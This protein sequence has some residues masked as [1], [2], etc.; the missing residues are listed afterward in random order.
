MGLATEPAPAP[1]IFLESKGFVFVQSSA[2][3]KSATFSVV[4]VD[5]IYGCDLSFDWVKSNR[6][7]WYEIWFKTVESDCMLSLPI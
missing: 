4:A 6:H 7:R 1:L 5:G 2:A 3:N